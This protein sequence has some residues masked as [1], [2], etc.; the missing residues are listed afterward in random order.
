MQTNQIQ[1][2]K[3]KKKKKTLLTLRFK[4]LPTS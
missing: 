4:V 1:K 2:K 3:K